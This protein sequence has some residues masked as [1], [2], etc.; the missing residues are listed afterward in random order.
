MNPT[1]EKVKSF[2]A[3]D[4]GLDVSIIEPNTAL[5]TSGMIDSFALIEMLSY[6]ESEFNAKIDI[7]DLGI[8][9][10][11]NLESIAALVENA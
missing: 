3:N 7:A 8:D 6:L 9:N 10:L 1:Q 2:L 4:L 5:F 11:D